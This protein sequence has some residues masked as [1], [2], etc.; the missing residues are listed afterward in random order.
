MQAKIAQLEKELAP[1][2][3]FLS[4]YIVRAAG[5]EVLRLSNRTA[6]QT[7]ANGIASGLSLYVLENDGMPVNLVTFMPRSERNSV[8]G[9]SRPPLDD[10]ERKVFETIISHEFE[11]Q[12]LLGQM[13]FESR[14]YE[15]ALPGFELRGVLKAE[16]WMNGQPV[17]TFLYERLHESLIVQEVDKDPIEETLEMIPAPVPQLPEPDDSDEDEEDPE[18]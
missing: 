7:M 15:V 2:E 1:L 10:E 5:G 6:A 8:I 16:N 4:D 18:E 12:P 14:G 13:L 11:R 3:T 17:D 9:F